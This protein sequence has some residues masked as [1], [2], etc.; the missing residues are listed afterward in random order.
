MGS[1]I[2]V[3]GMG[4]NVLRVPLHKVM[5][6]C[7]LF[8]GEMAVGVRPA[9]PVDGV[10][11]ILGNGIAGSRVWADVAPPAVVVS[12]PLVSSEPDE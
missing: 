1:Y 4:L 6:S 5:L 9:L 10:T 12:S 8:Q 11:M 3:L 7:D 2:P